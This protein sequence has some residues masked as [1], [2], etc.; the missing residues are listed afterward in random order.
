MG[1]V[2]ENKNFGG[3]NVYIRPTY[4][5]VMP[6]R[7]GPRLPLTEAQKVNMQFLKLQKHTGTISDKARKRLTNCVNWLVA[8]AKTKRIYSKETK[9]T[10]K[11]KVNFVTLTLPTL[12]HDISD[13]HFKKV[14]LHAFINSCRYRYGLKNYIWKVEAQAN[15]NIHAHFTT[16]TFLPHGGL[17]DVWNTI[18]DK[19]GLLNNY[20]DKH[21][22]MS[23]NDYIHAYHGNG[24]RTIEQLRR[25]YQFGQKSNWSDPNT[26]DVHAVYKIKDIGAYMAKYMSKSDKD[27]RK[28]KG[29][30]WRASYSLTRANKLSM[31]LPEDADMDALSSFFQPSIEY[32]E[33]MQESKLDGIPRKVGEIFFLKL[34]DWYDKI[35]GP[36]KDLYMNTLFAIRNG[37]DIDRIFEAPLKI[38]TEQRII[39]EQSPKLRQLDFFQPCNK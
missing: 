4:A 29:S 32:S 38:I 27:R 2:I 20:R 11:F 34:T 35:S 36:I 13:H 7:N 12:D 21:M 19:N 18:L 17:R 3:L 22:A 5:V 15:G 10:H 23:L 8:S 30:L 31:C 9:Q 14:L 33:I 37:I 39:Y 1:I 24:S 6:K 26:T 25:A 28:I 16:D